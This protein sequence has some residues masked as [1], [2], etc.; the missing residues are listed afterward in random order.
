M[1]SQR[2]LP[3]SPID[4]HATT[5][6]V[7]R[8]GNNTKDNTLTL[9]IDQLVSDVALVVTPACVAYFAVDRKTLDRDESIATFEKRTIGSSLSL[10][11]FCLAGAGYRPQHP[12]RKKQEFATAI[13]GA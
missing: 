9:Y 7:T 3:R 2:M 8:H 6:G 5:S 11:A 10:S 4:G 12:S 1:N 13:Y